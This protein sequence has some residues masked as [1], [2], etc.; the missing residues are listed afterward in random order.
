M[1]LKTVVVMVLARCPKST[2]VSVFVYCILCLD[3]GN[4][5]TSFFD[6]GF[7]DSTGKGSILNNTW[8]KKALPTDIVDCDVLKYAMAC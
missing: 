5:D 4:D 3:L 7:G 2:G 1:S 6:L 8:A